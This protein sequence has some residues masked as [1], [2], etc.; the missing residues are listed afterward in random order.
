MSPNSMHESRQ[1]VTVNRMMFNPVFDMS[2]RKDGV[3]I[4]GNYVF[5]G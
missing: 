1:S 4:V 2:K 3:K 5:C